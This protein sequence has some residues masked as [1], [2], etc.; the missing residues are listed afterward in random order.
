VLNSLRLL[1]GDDVFLRGLRRFY[2]DFRFQKA[3]TADV[4]KAF[5]A[6]S[7]QDLTNFFENWIHSSA[8][9]AVKMAWRVDTPSSAQELVVSL[10]Q[11]GPVF[12]VPIPVTVQYVDGTSQDFVVP[13]R[14]RTVEHR[15]PI[16]GPVRSVTANAGGM[17]LVDVL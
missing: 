14:A 1:L 11:V 17:V 5:E 3:G 16:R 7:G 6:E 10:E 13:V 8:I 9:P 15:L 2:G 4:Q 12:D